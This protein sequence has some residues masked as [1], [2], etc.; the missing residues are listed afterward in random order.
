MLETKWETIE[1]RP[2]KVIEAEIEEFHTIHQSEY[3]IATRDYLIML[4][5]LNEELVS[6]LK[7]ENRHGIKHE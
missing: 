7:F 3:D 6:S 4:L 2:S 5:N 1:F